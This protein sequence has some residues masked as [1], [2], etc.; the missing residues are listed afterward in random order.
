MSQSAQCLIRKCALRGKG[1]KVCVFCWNM[2]FMYS[3]FILHSQ[4]VNKK[5]YSVI[6]QIHGSINEVQQ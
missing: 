5:A 1:T 4:K 3:K 2:S 6:L